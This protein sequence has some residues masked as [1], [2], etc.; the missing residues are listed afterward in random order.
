[1]TDER[2]VVPKDTE[3]EAVFVTILNAVAAH[4][5]SPGRASDGLDLCFTCGTITENADY[6]LARAVL[7]AL[8]GDG[9]G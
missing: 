9:N 3:D 5:I 8:S 6:H 7:A 2:R 1:M 4:C